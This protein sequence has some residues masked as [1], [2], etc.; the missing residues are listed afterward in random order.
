MSYKAYNDNVL[1]KE[2]KR[3]PAAGAIII[4]N[5]SKDFVSAE[6]I[7][8]PND[9][10]A[11]GSIVMYAKDDARDIDVEGRTLKIVKL[12]DIVIK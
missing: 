3:T 1:V 4:S 7:S 12:K 2:L 10:I 5:S 9:D 8:A 6:V 11:E